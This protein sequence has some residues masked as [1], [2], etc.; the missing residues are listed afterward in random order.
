MLIQL[1]GLRRSLASFEDDQTDQ[2]AVR[3]W[4]HES[5]APREARDGWDDFR[6]S[7]LDVVGLAIGEEIADLRKEFQSEMRTSLRIAILEQAGLCPHVRG[8]WQTTENYAALDICMKDGAAW[9]AKHITPVRFRVRGGKFFRAKA[10]AARS[11]RS[12]SAGRRA[13]LVR[14]GSPA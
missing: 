14:G 3:K 9:I 13:R 12:A 6:E 1:V 4:L 10:S 7:L 2:L 11:G 8:V 5:N